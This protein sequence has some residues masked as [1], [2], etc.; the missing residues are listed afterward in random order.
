MLLAGIQPG[1]M[2]S[3]FPP[4]ACGN[5]E[6]VNHQRK[7]AETQNRKKINFRLGV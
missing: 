2:L 1:A 7:D 3:G 6:S 4:E 5:D